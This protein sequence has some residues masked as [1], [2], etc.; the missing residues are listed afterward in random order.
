MKNRGAVVWAVLVAGI[1][2]VMFLYRDRIHFDWPTFWQQLRHVDT[3]HAMA[4]ILLIYTTYWLRAIRWSV[5]VKPMKDV[6]VGPWWGRSSPDLRRWR[7]LG[8]WQIFR[9]HTL[10]RGSWG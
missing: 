9:G 4:G 8:D 10:W 2:V 1:A 3:F 5:F 6:G 7:C